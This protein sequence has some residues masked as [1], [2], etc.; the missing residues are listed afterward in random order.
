MSMD[1]FEQGL[2]ELW[3]EA[4]RHADREDFLPT[5]GACLARVIPLDALSVLERSASTSGFALRATWRANPLASAGVSSSAWSVPDTPSIQGWA[6]RRE[7][8]ERRPGERWKDRL[9]EITTDSVES[10]EFA[11]PLFAADSL[12]GLVIFAVDRELTE[13]ERRMLRSSLDPI[14]AVVGNDFRLRELGRLSARA[15]AE[16]DS[17]LSRLGRVTLNEQVVGAD[18]GLAPVMERVE[19]VARTDASVLILGETGSGK[20]VIARAIHDRSGRRDG[21][22]IRVNCGAVAPELIDSELFGHEKGSF[23]GAVAARRGWFERANGG[24]LFLDEIGELS[25]AVQVRLLRVLQ[26]GVVQRVGS[27]LERRVDVRVIAATHRDLPEMVRNRDFREDLWYRIAVFPIV[28]P[29]LRDRPGDLPAL[30]RHFIRRAANRAGVHEP[31]LFEAD[32]I[33]LRAYDWPGNVRE[34]GAVIER[35]VILGQGERLALDAA[36]G[37]QGAVPARASQ[38]IAPP[39]SG[40]AVSMA[41][42]AVET[43]ETVIDN[44]IRRVVTLCGGR[45]D[46]PH[47]AAR[48]LGLNVNTLR[49][50][51]RKLGIR[52]V[53]LVS[54]SE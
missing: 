41:D 14:A 29:P 26:D 10:W 16:R 5:L 25:A 47:G 40:E 19:Q 48:L 33:R 17:L 21:P 13:P 23:T 49:S 43:L 15:E 46:G 36:L 50:K 6:A 42:A 45:L 30:A 22:F 4:G 39:M 32:L 3:K 27:E 20:E 24:T 12:I 52:R 34:L 38:P 2:L 9:G 31:R 7:L 51:M 44:H 8:G 1:I 53:E 35:A 54:K 28:L 18:A 37:L 11:G